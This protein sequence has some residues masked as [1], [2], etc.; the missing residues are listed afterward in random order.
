MRAQNR[1][2]SGPRLRALA[3][4]TTCLLGLTL[5]TAAR[6]SAAHKQLAHRTAVIAVTNADV[7]HLLHRTDLPS[8]LPPSAGAPSAAVTSLDFANSSSAVRSRTAHTP[9]VRGPPGQALA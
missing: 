2:G 1:V 4:L 6:S 3:L 9:Q 7:A 5:V 8:G